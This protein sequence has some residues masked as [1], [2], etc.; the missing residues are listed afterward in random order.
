MRLGIVGIAG[1]GMAHA[2]AA[3]RL[4]W[5]VAAIIDTDA[6]RLAQLQAA[7]QWE[8]RYLSLVESMIPHDGTRFYEAL[9]PQLDVDLLVIATPPHT[10]RA[11]VERALEVT[12]APILCEKPTSYPDRPAPLPDDRRVTLSSEYIFHQQVRATATPITR[13]AMSS[14]YT[15]RTR[16][17]YL[18]PAALNFA[19]HAFSLLEAVGQ[20]VIGPVRPLT[21]GYLEV[22][23]TGG[24]VCCHFWHAPPFGTWIDG[25]SWPWE[26]PLFDR[27]LEAQHGL[28][29]WNESVEK[30]LLLWDAYHF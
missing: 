11:L 27:Q 7:D 28:F 14:P 30:E 17:D 4:D 2:I 29:H 25:V 16:W 22:Y 23:T 9:P 26:M 5:Q 6:D 8:N 13:I 15:Q 10:H 21:G 19:P 12:D 24:W 18:L 20:S 1:V 3:D